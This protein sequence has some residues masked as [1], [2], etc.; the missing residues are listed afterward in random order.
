MD[1]AR[2]VAFGIA[3][4]NVVH[5]IAEGLATMLQMIGAVVFSL[6]VLDMFH[7]WT[8]ASTSTTA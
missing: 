1:L 2:A 3:G 5:L 7:R 8:P 4:R 6:D